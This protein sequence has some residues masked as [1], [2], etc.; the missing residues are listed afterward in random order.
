[1]FGVEGVRAAQERR[2]IA[3][4]YEIDVPIGSGGMGQ[5]FR[6]RHLE[7]GIDVAVKL[8][9]PDRAN[10]PAT[11]ER[12]RRE[13]RTAARIRSGHVVRVL[14]FGHDGGRPYL[15]MELLRGETLK[16]RLAARDRLGVMETTVL[17]RDVCRA[18]TAAHDAGIVHRD[19]KPGNLF[20]ERSG[21]TETVKVL[22]FG[23]A[24]DAL[25]PDTQ[26]T[27][28]G[29]VLGSHGYMSP[30]QLQ[31]APVDG[32]SDLWAV[33]AVAFRALTG[34]RIGEQPPSAATLSEARAKAHLPAGLDG[35]FERALRKN[36]EER[37]QDAATFSME[38]AR[39][40]NVALP[41]DRAQGGGAPAS[42][43]PTTQ[44]FAAPPRR[45]SLGAGVALVVGGVAMALLVVALATRAP[46]GTDAPRVPPAV[47]PAP[48]ARP[49]APPLP[50]FETQDPLPEPSAAGALAEPARGRSS[51]ERTP[52]LRASPREIRPAHPQASLRP[53]ATLA[54]SAESRSATDPLFG[55]PV[56]SMPPPPSGSAAPRGPVIP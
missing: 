54:T 16:E 9:H 20:I 31:G 24:R 40:T 33:A 56:P 41:A 28:Q 38:L 49:P 51:P 53:P 47:E 15:V 7:L 29:L 26:V 11:V 23:I 6:A 5:V 48:G 34:E 36:P 3:G 44:T 43:E 8:L 46:G 14:D 55:L 13:A 30:E 25:D 4:K 45:P 32:R 19:L 12:F 10:D 21:D 39:A 37:F 18:L 52:P 42:T 1:V 22:D 2:I 50:A 17:V 35:F 27:R